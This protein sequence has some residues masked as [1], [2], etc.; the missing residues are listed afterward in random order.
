M[1]KEQKPFLREK[2]HVREIGLFGSYA[3]NEAT[4]DSDIDFLVELFPPPENYIETKEALRNYLSIL[5]GRKVDLANPRSLKPH[6]KE[7]ILKQ[8]VYA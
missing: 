8:A 6:F 4:E 7:R 3:R 5:F 2:F 1:L